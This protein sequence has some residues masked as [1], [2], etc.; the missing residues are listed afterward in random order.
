[1]SHGPSAG[2]WRDKTAARAGLAEIYIRPTPAPCCTALGAGCALQLSQQWLAQ[3]GIDCP[4]VEGGYKSLRGFLYEYLMNYCA[5]NM[6]T[7]VSGM[8][9]TGKTEIIQALPTGLDLEGAANHKGSSFG[10]PL[11]EQPAQIDFENRIAIDLLKVAGS[12]PPV[13]G[14]ARG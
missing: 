9:G 11:D 14:G 5:N 6:F 13:D 4:R 7:V 10:R 12:A 1:M 2:P 3:A 8:T